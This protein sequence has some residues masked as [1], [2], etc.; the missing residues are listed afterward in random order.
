MKNLFFALS[1]FLLSSCSEN[2]TKLNVTVTYING[3]V[4][5]FYDIICID[6]IVHLT[7]GDVSV[8]LPGFEN[9]K[10]IASNVRKYH[11]TK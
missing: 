7:N 5:T 4:E 2:T 1:L 8:I 9:R 11:L 3:D 6:S 10:T